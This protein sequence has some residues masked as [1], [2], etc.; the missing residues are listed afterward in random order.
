MNNKDKQYLIEKVGL[1][2]HEYSEKPWQ[3]CFKCRKCGEEGGQLDPLDPGDM[4]K[5]WEAMDVGDKDE[6]L[7][8]LWDNT[9]QDYFAFAVILADT[10]KRAQAMLKYFKKKEK[11]DD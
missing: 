8:L 3:D 9:G 1:C 4:A 10:P 2:W 11:E 6:F 5:I 7:S